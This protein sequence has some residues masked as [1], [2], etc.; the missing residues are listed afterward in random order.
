MKTINNKQ[1]KTQLCTH[2]KLVSRCDDYHKY[3]KNAFQIGAGNCSCSDYFDRLYSMETSIENIKNNI[4]DITT[5]LS[6]IEND[7][8]EILNSISN[9]P[10]PSQNT[11]REETVTLSLAPP[12]ASSVRSTESPNTVAFDS[13]LAEVEGW[14]STELDKFY[15]DY[16]AP[17][18]AQNDG[19]LLAPIPV[20]ALCSCT[21]IPSSTKYD[22]QEQSIKWDD[23]SG[24]D[25]RK[26]A[27]IMQFILANRSNSTRAMYLTNQLIGSFALP[28]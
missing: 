5:R 25:E 17:V 23:L 18:I 15:S 13:L 19:N 22:E 24:D 3:S 26:R 20:S 6:T 4:T 11:A 2:H 9:D 27:Y 28:L 8:R 14:D 10:P 21:R 12:T 1:Y 16:I 7:I